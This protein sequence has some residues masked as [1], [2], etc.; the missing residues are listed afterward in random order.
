VVFNNVAQIESFAK[1]V[2]Q[3][4]RTEIISD[5]RSG[6]GTRFREIRLMNGREV[7]QKYELI[8]ERP[9]ERFESSA[10]LV[11]PIGTQSSPRT[12]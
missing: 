5:L 11:E 6:I 3:I 1:V 8:D 10:T 9:N 2:P 12:Q 7:T 4:V